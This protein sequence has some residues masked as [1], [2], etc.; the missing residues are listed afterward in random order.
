MMFRLLSGMSI[1]EGFLLKALLIGLVA[2]PFYFLNPFVPVLV[3]LGF[4]VRAILEAYLPTH[5]IYVI[6]RTYGSD[7]L[8]ILRQLDTFIFMVLNG[9]NFIALAVLHI[10]KPGIS[11]ELV[12][13]QIVYFNG[14]LVWSLIYT[15]TMAVYSFYS[16]QP[17]LLGSGWVLLSTVFVLVLGALAWIVVGFEH[18]TWSLLAWFM[19]LGLWYFLPMKVAGYMN[20]NYMPNDPY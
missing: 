12:F 18:F 15:Q 7:F 17:R 19:L 10:G 2:L 4:M 3:M 11:L 1:S 13:S 16:G 8:S 6:Y 14:V 9:I 20:K 5:G